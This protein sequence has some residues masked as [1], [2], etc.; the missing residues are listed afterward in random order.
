[1]DVRK[2]YESWCENPLFNEM[3]RR[4]LIAI[5][6]NELEIQDRFYRELEFGTGGLRGVIG[7]GTNRMNIYTVRRATQG[8]SNY[9]LRE[10]GEKKGV[11]IA[12]DSRN[13]SPEFAREAALCL[14]ANGICAYLFDSLRPTP[15]LSY[16]V[17]KLGCKAGI[18]VTASHNPPEYNGYKVYWEDGAQITAPK[19]QEIIGEVKK[20]RDYAQA[21]T[22]ELKE[23]EKLGLY[24]IIG[25]EL[26][27]CYLEELKKLV[28]HPEMI[29]N[30]QKQLKIV[31][32]PLHGTGNH[33]VRRILKEL[34]FEEVYVVPEQENP[35]GNFPTVSYPNPEDSEAFSLALKLAKKVDADVVL[36]TD[37]DADRLGIYGKNEK[38]GEYEPF[39][40]N[41]SGMI[42]LEYILSQKKEKQELLKNGAVVTTIVSG[43]MA[44]AITDA[45]GVELKET[46]T[47]FKYI[48]EQMKFFEQSGSHHF[49]FGY[50]ESYGCLLGNHARDKD[51]VVAAMALC[52]A[53]AYYLTKGMSLCQQMEKLYEK[54]GHYRENLC[55]ITLKGMDG[56]ENI[57]G[58]L[59]TI[60]KNPPSS[61]GDFSVKRFRDYETGV[62]KDLES[63]LEYP[64]SLPFSNVLYF[65]LEDGAWCC[66]RPSG[67][68]PKVKYYIGVK[69]SG[70]CDAAKKL[71]EL[72]AAVKVLIIN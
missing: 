30:Q 44:K 58:I 56:A 17:R 25:R 64:T 50:E 16:A 37:P 1:M 40:G 9:I 14:A 15:V 42:I 19:D 71:A 20:V 65:E 29:R 59:E 28:I 45:Y 21:R 60:R 13:Y 26:D 62:V 51:A 39:T 68:E 61:I 47:G 32:T 6:D 22:M 8:L 70:S 53:A 7:A 24:R 55:T 54:Y 67:T 69:G 57:K 38:S 34:G 41:M 36:A 49:L 66:I 31:Y 72:T 46:L 18:V 4:E 48:G 3:T 2:E 27:D 23:A 52:E 10:K 63:G 11:A 12:Y 5:K 33:F 35:D 43:K